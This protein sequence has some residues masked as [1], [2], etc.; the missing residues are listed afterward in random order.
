MNQEQKLIA[1]CKRL[2]ECRLN[3]KESS[4]WTHRDY[5]YLSDLIYEKSKIQLS[6]STLKRL[7]K[8]N[9]KSIPHQNT[10]DALAAFIDYESWNIFKQKTTK[11][12][13]TKPP[14]NSKMKKSKKQSNKSIN[15]IFALAFVLGVAAIIAFSINKESLPDFGNVKFSSK[16]ITL[17][18]PNSV[19]FKYDFSET[20]IDSAIIQQSWD[21][22][23]RVKVS[24]DKHSQTC[25][26][27]YPGFFN[28]KLIINDSIVKQHQLHITTA[29]WQVLAR[30]KNQTEPAYF[31]VA[32]SIL[33]DSL[34]VSPEY[35]KNNNF[36]V[37]P[38]PF[39][40]EYYYSNDM[41]DI[42]SDNFVFETEVKNNKTEGGLSCQYVYISLLCQNGVIKIPLSEKGCISNLHAII[43]MNYIDGK[44]NDL[45]A[46][47]F[48]MNEWHLVKCQA[49]DGDLTLNIDGKV[50]ANEKL[51][52]EVGKIIG[53][54]YSF[55]GC[56]AV[57]NV[58]L[59]D[60]K[61]ATYFKH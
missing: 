6:V 36:N 5:E 30:H 21:K 57:R 52:T 49:K 55:Y 54:S 60:H 38:D 44:E 41:G 58:K 43:G 24:K 35:L 33:K 26:Y 12:N 1:E 56:G 42:Y 39:W 14:V 9:Y 29:G 22:R 8:P 46:F 31:K 48:N 18:V 47:G 23:L 16:S 53:I 15:I 32:S 27:Y 10:L 37:S 4:E 50:V 59:A 13:I 40:V 28:A 19:V 61:G 3:W 25:I 7:W 45:S 2:I 34:Y 11:F 20:E 51:P 17:G